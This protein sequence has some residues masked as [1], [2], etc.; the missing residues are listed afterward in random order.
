MSFKHFKPAWSLIEV[1]VALA[2]FSLVAVSLISLSAGSLNPWL[3]LGASNQAEDLAQEGLEAVRSIKNRAWNELNFKTSGL[4]LI[5]NVWSLMGEGTEETIGDYSRSLSFTDVCRDTQGQIVSCSVG[6]LD[7]HIKEAT[8]KVSW[9]VAPTTKQ[10]VRTTYLT[11]WNSFFWEQTDWSGGDRQEIWNVSDRFSTA[12]NVNI[13]RRG[14]I[15][16][17]KQ[18]NGPLYNFN[19]YLVSSAFSTGGSSKIQVIEWDQVI[20][21]SASAIKFQVRTAPDNNGVPGTWSQWFGLSGPNDY[22]V[23]YQGNLIDKSLND[24]FWVQ[25]RVE[26]SGDGQDTPVLNKVK[27]NYKS[28]Q[29]V[30]SE[31]PLDVGLVAHWRL[32]GNANDYKN[33]NNCLASNISYADGRLNQAATFASSSPSIFYKTNPNLMYQLTSPHT[34]AL[35]VKMDSLIGNQTLFNYSSQYGSRQNSLSWQ[36]DRLI[37]NSCNSTC[38][39]YNFLTVGEWTHIVIPV[40]VGG[41]VPLTIYKNGQPVGYNFCEGSWIYGDWEYVLL[42][43]GSGWV[44]NLN[45]S[46]LNGTLDEVR[47]YNRTLSATEILNLYNSY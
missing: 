16:L 34:I 4:S 13:T 43:L 2:I 3:N 6:R 41:G 30:N 5:E 21:D 32:D 37:F 25:Y 14:Q 9:G 24:R 44:N 23:N 18:D 22:F 10:I 20:P 28:G 31:D 26:L 1:I 46:Y 47:I 29:R 40:E 36:N 17:S 15:S 19:G 8:V 45:T 11:N 42:S 27:I 33:L 39:F 35:W 7:P 12:L 38:H